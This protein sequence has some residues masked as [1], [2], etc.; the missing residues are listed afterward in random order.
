MKT[1][2]NNRVLRFKDLEGFYDKNLLEA[3][4]LGNFKELAN[5]SIEDKSNLDF[6]EPLLYAVRNEFNTYA[7]Y[8]YLAESLQNNISLATEVIAS[9]PE[10]IQGTAISSNS[11]FILEHADSYPEIVQYMSNSLKSNPSV[12]KDLVSLNNKEVINNIANDSNIL[13][14]IISNEPSLNNNKE[15]MSAIIS[16]NGNALELV[17]PELKDDYN[18]LKDIYASSS[19]ALEYTANHV[20]EFGEKGLTAAKEVIIDNSSND[21]INGFEKQISKVREQIESHSISETLSPEVKKLEFS[22]KQ[23]QRHIKFIERIKN[24]DVDPIRA[25]KLISSFCKNLDPEYKKQI[26]QMLKIDDAIVKKQQ[27][28]NKTGRIEIKDFA[29]VA[30]NIDDPSKPLTDELSELNDAKTVINKD[31]EKE[32]SGSIDRE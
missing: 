5:L 3:L 12:I 21:A 2:S 8:P 14:S 31:K 19:S 4:K 22:E 16:K 26:E 17:S 23:L 24:G 13:T 20:N 11:Q 15:F 1:F 9:E 27:E 6:I 28:A 10:L 29:E 18:F 32:N 7:V 30:R 25:A